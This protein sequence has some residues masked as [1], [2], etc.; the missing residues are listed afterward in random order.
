MLNVGDKVTFILGYEFDLPNETYPATI[1]SDEIKEG[2]FTGLYMVSVKEY[3]EGEPF[4]C[5]ADYLLPT[6][7]QGL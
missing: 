5:C 6:K 2:E 7:P 1:V 3:K 4:F